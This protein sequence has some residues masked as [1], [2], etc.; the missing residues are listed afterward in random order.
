M[1]IKIGDVLTFKTGTQN[2]KM[3]KSKVFER[4]IGCG[5]MVDFGENVRRI[6][7]I[8]CSRLF[9]NQIDIITVNGVDV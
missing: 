5:L 6:D 7:G 1:S 4:A 9:I 2:T 3:Y 8:L